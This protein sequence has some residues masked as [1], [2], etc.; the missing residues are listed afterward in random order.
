MAA[1]TVVIAS[2]GRRGRAVDRA[3]DDEQL[4]NHALRPGLPIVA[5]GG[6]HR[7]GPVHAFVVLLLHDP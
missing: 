7:C 1:G 3:L 2:S 5:L 4:G 6:R